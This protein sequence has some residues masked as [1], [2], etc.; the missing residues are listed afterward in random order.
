MDNGVAEIILQAV[1]EVRRELSER[2]DNMNTERCRGREDSAARHL[3]VVTRLTRLE[4]KIDVTNGR[5]ASGEARLDGHDNALDQI[6]ARYRALA[7]LMRIAG[8]PATLATAAAVT[9]VVT[10]L[11]T[12]AVT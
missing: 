10:V 3:E 6:N 7:W 9:V 1:G 8:R 12:R 11:I 5:V 2:L 4:G